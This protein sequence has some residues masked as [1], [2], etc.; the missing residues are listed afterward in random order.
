MIR[1]PITNNGYEKLAKEI[2]K[3]KEIEIPDVIEDIRVA[4]S[5]GDLT[6]NAEYE[7]ATER[8]GFLLARLVSLQ[9]LLSKLVI[10][11]PTNNSH[12]KVSF[13]ST[14]KIINI[15]TE[16]EFIYTLLGGYESNPS[17]GIIS[18]N[19]PLAKA[20]IGKEVDDEVKVI[21]NKNTVYYEIEEIYFDKNRIQLEDT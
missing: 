10:I 11:D 12:K 3:F 17:K 9:Q 15:D 20:F 8:Q 18:Y 2:K 7:A 21:L 14:F 16:E 4:A 13:G 19:S 1:E 5:Y 6:E